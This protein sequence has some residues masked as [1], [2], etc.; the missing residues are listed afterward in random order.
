VFLL[1]SRVDV[2]LGEF[3]E[4]EQDLKEFTDVHPDIILEESEALKP[5]LEGMIT[6]FQELKPIEKLIRFKFKDYGP[7]FD[8]LSRIIN[9]KE[10]GKFF[11]FLQVIPQLSPKRAYTKRVVQTS[12]PVIAKEI[13]EKSAEQTNN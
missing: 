2:L 11:S 1:E 8:N 13:D 5:I 9:E 12:I 4:F 3:K 7:I 6:I 10:N